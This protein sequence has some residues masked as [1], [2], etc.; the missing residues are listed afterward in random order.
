MDKVCGSCG[1]TGIAGGGKDISDGPCGS[2]D[3]EGWV[4]R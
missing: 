2:C 1:G 3:G 4:Q